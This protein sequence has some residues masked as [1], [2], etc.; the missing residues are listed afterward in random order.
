MELNYFKDHLFDLIN[1]SDAFD[2]HEI[3]SDD[4]ANRFTVIVHDGSVFKIECAKME[5]SI[6]DRP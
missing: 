6:S 4:H 1:E 3:I 5:Q 2:V